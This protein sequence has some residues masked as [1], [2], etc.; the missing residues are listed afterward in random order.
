MHLSV[1]EITVHIHS[2]FPFY[3]YSFTS[4]SELSCLQRHTLWSSC[5]NAISCFSCF[6]LVFW[7]LF[8]CFKLLFLPFQLLDN[9]RVTNVRMCLALPDRQPHT[10]NHQTGTAVS[11]GKKNPTKRDALKIQAPLVC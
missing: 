4:A 9:M 10:V 3:L 7:N 1:D 6:V 5:S 8:A 2:D 11:W